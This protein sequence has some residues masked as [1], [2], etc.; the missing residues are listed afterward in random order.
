MRYGRTHHY[1]VGCKIGCPCGIQLS[2]AMHAC[3]TRVQYALCPKGA[4]LV[5]YRDESIRLFQ[6]FACSSWT[7]Y[8]PLTAKLPSR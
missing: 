3:V 6:F 1:P 5:L 7:G 8:A 4:S 2:A